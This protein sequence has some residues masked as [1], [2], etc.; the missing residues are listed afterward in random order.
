MTRVPLALLSVATRMT[1][2]HMCLY[3][4]VAT[5][6]HYNLYAIDQTKVFWHRALSAFKALPDTK[7]V[8]KCGE[9]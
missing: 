9:L 2:P 7:K 1:S 4:N 3:R 6:S 5:G 8:D